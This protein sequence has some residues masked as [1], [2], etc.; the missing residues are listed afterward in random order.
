MM[1]K[2]VYDIRYEKSLSY[3]IPTQG[4]CE[5]LDIEKVYSKTAV[6]LY[7]FYDDTAL[8]YLKYI[9]NIPNQ[10]A[11]YIISSC[12][13]VLDLL[14]KNI[15][16]RSIT[17]ILKENRGRDV[18]A[19]LVTAKNTISKYE[20]IC[21]AHD[22]KAHKQEMVND[23]EFWIENLWSNVLGSGAYIDQ[24]L[25]K[26]QKN[27]KLGILAP[28]DPI[29]DNFSTWYGFGWYDSFEI[30]KRL[31]EEMKL[32]T[33]L[34][35]E[36]PP[37]AVGTVLWFRFSALEK[38]FDYGWKYEDFDDC[39]LRKPNYISYGIERIFPYVAQDAGFDTG[40]IMTLEYAQ[41]QNDYI[42]FSV[43]ELFT[44][45]KL[46]LP[47]H[48]VKDVEC[49]DKNMQRL[50]EFVKGNTNI[51][52][53]GAGDW[54]KFCLLI[55]RQLNIEPNGFIVSGIKNQKFVDAL[56]VYNLYELEQ[57]NLQNSKIIVTVYDR[58]RQ[59]QIEDLLVDLKIENYLIWLLD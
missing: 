13:N 25:D 28:P 17:Y 31:V 40:E 6:V 24:I 45:I 51:F 35:I 50:L 37:I 15:K 4:C 33:D 10:I 2:N 39:Q 49:Y 3:I 19:L 12:Q 16:N 42:H 58:Q 27:S 7:I 29:G 44:R 14:R 38:L 1:M 22:K 47:F 11:L 34:K 32:K 36:K 52:L 57:A 59:K 26:F 8:S 53:Y 21:F 20:Y 23:T 55:L 9:D 56:P 43:V 48:K 46:F 41:K 5:Q 18:S 30:T 54:G